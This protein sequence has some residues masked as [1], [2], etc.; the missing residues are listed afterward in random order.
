MKL[1]SP[2]VFNDLITKS[3]Y[4]IHVI[5]SSYELLLKRALTKQSKL[6]ALKVEF[7]ILIFF[8][9]DCFQK[10]SKDVAKGALS[11]IF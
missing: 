1:F 10:L 11:D 5:K 9:I 8:F 2:L 7:P 4:A 6:G 3:I